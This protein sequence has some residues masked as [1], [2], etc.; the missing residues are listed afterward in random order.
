MDV[1]V[2]FKQGGPIVPLVFLRDYSPT[3][4]SDAQE[5]NYT[6]HIELLYVHGRFGN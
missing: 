3:R 4:R 2:G 5:R 1:E 6:G